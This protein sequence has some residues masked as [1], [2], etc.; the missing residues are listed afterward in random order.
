MNLIPKLQTEKIIG[1]VLP[2][3]QGVEAFDLLRSSQYPKIVLECSN[4]KPV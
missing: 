2:L 1:K 4:H 3:S